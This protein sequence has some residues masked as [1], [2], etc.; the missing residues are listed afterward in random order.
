MRHQAAPETNRSRG[1]SKSNK[2]TFSEGSVYPAWPPLPAVAGLP[3]V[4]LCCLRLCPSTSA[5][6]WRCTSKLSLRTSQTKDNSGSLPQFPAPVFVGDLGFERKFMGIPAK[7][8]SFSSSTFKVDDYMDDLEKNLLTCGSF[9]F[10]MPFASQPRGFWRMSAGCFYRA[11]HPILS[12]RPVS[13][14]PMDVF[15]NFSAPTCIIRPLL[16]LS[17]SLPLGIS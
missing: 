4:G 14:S 17:D 13:I 5:G 15:A 6:L 8:F 1:A 12:K 3:R 16:K 2:S 11:V 10:R 7:Y 9:W